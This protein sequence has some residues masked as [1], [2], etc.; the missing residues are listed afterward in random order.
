MN[1]KAFLKALKACIDRIVSKAGFTYAERRLW[2][3]KTD[4][5][6]DHV[7]LIIGGESYF[8][9]NLIVDIPPPPG[10]GTDFQGLAF[11]NLGTLVGKEAAYRYPSLL[12]PGSAILKTV[13]EDLAKGLSWFCLFESPEACLAYLRSD[14][15]PNEP[16]CRPGSPAFEYCVSYLQGLLSK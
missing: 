12:R 10:W 6:C 9:P 3:R 1:R 8:M 11:G 2:V 14:R 16:Y 7:M 15:G 13:E 4:W 5:K